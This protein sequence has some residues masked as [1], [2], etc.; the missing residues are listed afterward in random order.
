MQ[1][2]LMEPE[3]AR[4]GRS[5]SATL[6]PR[7]DSRPADTATYRAPVV[8]PPMNRVAVLG[9]GGSGKTHLASRLGALL[10]LSVTHLDA[11]YYDA[12]WNPLPH[13]EFA[14]LQRKLV[15]QPRWLIEGNYAATLPIRLAAA[16]TVIFLDLPAITCLAGIAQRRWR[17]R[18]GQHTHD[19]VYDRV[20]VAFPR[21]VC[22]YRGTMRPRVQ[23]LLSD[24][25]DEARVITLTS[26]REPFRTSC[27]GA[28]DRGTSQNG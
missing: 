1:Y 19:G 26:P 20:T 15:T 3:G 25:A 5:T 27:R 21:Y 16:D 9:C 18:G 28:D 24:H 23:A 14:A 8:S 13:D 17:Y 11:L 12:D 10:D 4:A 2:L 6:T 22:S 7:A